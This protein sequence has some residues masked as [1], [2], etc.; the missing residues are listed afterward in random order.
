MSL[1][2][3]SKVCLIVI[4][5]FITVTAST[6][7]EPSRKIS[8]TSICPMFDT[9]GWVNTQMSGRLLIRSGTNG[10]NILLTMRDEF[11]KGD[12]HRAVY[13]FFPE[14]KSLRKVPDLNWDA[15]ASPSSECVSRSGNT[16]DKFNISGEKLFFDKKEVP[17]KGSVLITAASS[18]S[19][20]NV[21]ILSA[22]GPRMKSPMPFLGGGQNS[23]GST[24]SPVIFRDQWR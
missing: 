23:R 8:Q 20:M 18:P 16:K 2:A 6:R 22:D 24:L 3:A 17:V 15:A 1:T 12:R 5:L 4:L 11:E 7:A 19:G 14:A 10:K 21:A 13:E 9:A